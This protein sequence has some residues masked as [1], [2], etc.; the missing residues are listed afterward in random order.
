MNDELV[1]AVCGPVDAGKSSL[2]GVLTSGQLD[3]GR[4]DARLKILRHP[5][6][7]DSGRTS[8]ISMN[9]IKYILKDSKQLEIYNTKAKKNTEI[10]KLKEISL[11][12]DGNLKEKVISFM[13]L[14]GH[15]KYLKTTVFGVTGMFL[16]EVLLLLV[17]I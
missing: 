12:N 17:L 4:G 11:L 15:E 9:P 13:D 1:V 6:E 3:D 8:N 5:H 14:A 2:I 10:K 7:Q 16:I